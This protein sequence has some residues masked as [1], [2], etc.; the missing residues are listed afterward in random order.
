MLLAKEAYKVH[1][2]TS[3]VFSWSALSKI[4][5]LSLVILW[6]KP[7]KCINSYRCQLRSM[8]VKDDSHQKRTNSR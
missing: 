4:S 7:K 8:D 5:L 6:A 1:C 3:T 2:G